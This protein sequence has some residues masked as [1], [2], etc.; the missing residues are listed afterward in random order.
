MSRHDAWPDMGLECRTGSGPRRV[1]RVSA[2]QVFGRSPRAVAGQPDDE[3]GANRLGS[4]HS[5]PRA[6]AGLRK[7][8]LRRLLTGLCG[9]ALAC[10]LAGPLGAEAGKRPPRWVLAKPSASTQTEKPVD[11]RGGDPCK[12]ADP[13]FGDYRK[14]DRGLVFGEMLLP[15]GLKLTDGSFDVVFH[16]HY[17][18]RA[19]IHWVETLRSGVLVGVDLGVLSG[20]YTAKFNGTDEFETLVRS[21]E[22]GVAARLHVPRA[23]ARRIGLSAWSAGYGAVGAILRSDYGQQHVDSVIL[24]DGLHTDRVDSPAGEAA[25][26]P[27][28]DFARRAANGETLM[29]ISHSS[30]LPRYASTT[31]TANYLIWQLGGK[32]QPVGGDAPSEPF[33]LERINEYSNGNFHVYG[34]AGNGPTDHCAQLALYRDALRR[35]LAPRWGLATVKELPPP[36]FDATEVRAEPADEE[37]ERESNNDNDG[38]A[39][40]DTAPAL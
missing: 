20:P 36:E 35:W 30:V 3:D 2:M 7:A 12:P 5:R 11:E 23:H 9:G 33:G 13:G 34:Y 6:R 18:D 29:Y 10:M 39:S 24:L 31:Q 27:F 37:G 8:A 21:V 40:N 22:R 15:K 25:L 32:P 4:I 28:L 26:A 38:R 1:L 14:W 19:R 17:H 16:F